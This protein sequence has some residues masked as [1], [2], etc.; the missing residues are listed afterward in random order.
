MKR[1]TGA[2]PVDVGRLSNN[3]LNTY[4]TEAAERRREGKTGGRG[5]AMCAAVAARQEKAREKEGQRMS[6]SAMTTL[7]FPLR[8]FRATSIAVFSRSVIAYNKAPRSSSYS[9]WSIGFH[10]PSIQPTRG[11]PSSASL[12]IIHHRSYPNK[13]EEEEELRAQTIGSLMAHILQWFFP[14]VFFFLNFVMSSCYHP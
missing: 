7:F 13:E 10:P 5:A 9:A 4:Q 6:A 3:S 2:Y 8:R 11:C 14:G 1:G 12:V